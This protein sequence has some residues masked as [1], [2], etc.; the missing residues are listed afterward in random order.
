MASIYGT[1]ESFNQICPQHSGSYMTL[2]G[3]ATEKQEYHKADIMFRK[4][5]ALS[6]ES[7][8]LVYHKMWERL[9]KPDQPGIG[10][11]A[12]KD[13]SVWHKVRPPIAEPALPASISDQ[14]F[15]KEEGIYDKEK[16]TILKEAGR[17][18]IARTSLAVAM[19]WAAK[20][21]DQEAPGIVR[22]VSRQLR[23]AGCNQPVNKA[24]SN[25]FQKIQAKAGSQESDFGL[26]AFSNE[27]GY[28]LA[29][30]KKA[31]A[32]NECAEEVGESIPF[33]TAF[34]L[35]RAA[36]Q[37]KQGTA[38][39]ADLDFDIACLLSSDCA[40]KVYRK[41]WEKS[42]RSN[43]HPHFGELAFHNREGFSCSLE[44]RV[45]ALRECAREL[46]P[47]DGSTKIL[48]MEIARKM[49]QEHADCLE[50]VEKRDRMPF[51]QRKFL[52]VTG[53]FGTLSPSDYKQLE[54]E[55]DLDREKAIVSQEAKALEKIES[56]IIA[57]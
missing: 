14:I 30:Q 31:E 13:Y 55:E 24:L 46:V 28:S 35:F 47:I 22:E 32:L 25:L 6:P 41:I 26:R 54:Y 21:N 23:S 2:A 43:P 57:R 12:F 19:R 9:G 39:S 29:F 7:E 38:S 18:L 36:T 33:Q 11:A 40:G 37:Y 15:G 42:D 20:T 27:T 16:A 49:L 8:R 50:S 53:S 17:D 10:E 48:D 44:V 3:L 34:Y 1:L 56:E 5:C 52:Q 45:E 51:L 4:A